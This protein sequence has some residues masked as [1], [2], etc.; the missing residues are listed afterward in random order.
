LVAGF[1]GITTPVTLRFYGWNSEASGGSYSIDNVVISGSTTTLSVKQN[2][3]AGLNVYPNPVTDGNLYI[4]SSSSN[5]KTI[6]VYDLL[7]KQVLESKTSNNAVNVSNFKGGAYI[8]RITEEGKT[9]TRKLI[10]E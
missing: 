2:T 9:D 1:A 6:V 8:V 10:I 4:T 5:A 3:F 7:G